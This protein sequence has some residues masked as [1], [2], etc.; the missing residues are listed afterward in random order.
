MSFVDRKHGGSLMGLVGVGAFIG[1]SWLAA[2]VGAP[3]LDPHPGEILIATAS[4]PNDVLTH[5]DADTEFVL[6]LPDGASCPGDSQHDQ[7]RF[8]SFAIPVGDRPE[9]I[10]YGPIGPEPETPGRY[11]MFLTDTS[12]FVHLTL[13]SNPLAGMPAR[14][15]LLP[16]MSFAVVAGAPIPTG[17]YRIGVACTLFTTT[18]TYWDVDV[19]ITKTASGDLRWR[20]SDVSPDVVRSHES[21]HL[22]WWL[23]A[24][25][26]TLTVAGAA[27]VMLRRLRTSPPLPLVRKVSR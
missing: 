7:Y 12:S 2:P 4:A 22:W 1:T 18:T 25:I 23:A 8:Q 26:G 5:G 27:V 6:V 21:G 16:A 9:E 17:E 24:G 13:P 10:A 11:A 19:V 20:R 15:P 3:P 14:I